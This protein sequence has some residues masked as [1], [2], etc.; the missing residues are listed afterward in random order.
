MPDQDKDK[1]EGRSDQAVGKAK[2]YAGKATGDE[3]TEA[4]GKADQ[5]TGKVKETFGKAKEKVKDLTD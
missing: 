3:D 5:V 4:E 1:W 2:E